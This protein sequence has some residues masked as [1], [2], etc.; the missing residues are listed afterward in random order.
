M[1]FTIDAARVEQQSSMKHD[2][3]LSRHSTPDV[4]DPIDVARTAANLTRLFYYQESATTNIKIADAAGR[5][6]YAMSCYGMN[7]EEVCDVAEPS[8]ARVL[9]GL[10][11][12]PRLGVGQ[13]QIE[14]KGR[15]QRAEVLSHIVVLAELHEVAG[16]ILDATADD[17]VARH[18]PAIRRWSEDALD[19]LGCLTKLQASQA[20]QLQVARAR[21]RLTAVRD[22]TGDA[23]RPARRHAL[24]GLYEPRQVSA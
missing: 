16:R 7:Y 4:A 22:K 19:T 10:S 2:E 21:Q 18:A 8:V 17:E 14:R 20:T 6:V 23:R 1:Q 3:Y 11:A 15:L 5:L 24:P 12:D 13:R 9:A